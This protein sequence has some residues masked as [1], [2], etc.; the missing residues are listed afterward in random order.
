MHLWCID[1]FPW[2]CATGQN[3]LRWNLASPMTTACVN[4]RR[5]LSDVTQCFWSDIWSF[6]RGLRLGLRLEMMAQPDFWKT[7]QQAEMQWFSKL[8]NKML[9]CT[10]LLA[11]SAPNYAKLIVLIPSKLMSYSI[12]K[13]TIQE[14]WVW[15]STELNSLLEFPTCYKQ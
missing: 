10:H 8:H 6:D 1:L 5:S 14:V 4:H 2:I 15:F 3:R 13:Y 11:K 12:G 7:V 9:V